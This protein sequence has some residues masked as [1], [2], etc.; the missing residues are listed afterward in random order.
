MNP[1]Q[2]AA[3]KISSASLD[4][5]LSLTFIPAAQ[6]AAQTALHAVY[7][8]LHEVPGEARD[9]GVADVKLRWWEEEIA[10]LYAGK[11]R[12]PLTQALLPHMA[13]LKARQAL[14]LDLI[15]GTR[16]DIAGAGFPSFEDVKRYCFRHSGALSQLSAMLAGGHAEET[17][18]AARLLGNATCLADIAATG[19]AAAL[20]G[21]LYFA[22][23]DL[24]LRGVDKHING[25]T[26]A[27]APVRALVQDYEDR[28][29]A[30]RAAALR[31]VPVAERRAL[32]V[33]QVRSALTLKRARKQERAGSAAAAEPVG[34]HPLSALF[35]AWRAAR[36]SN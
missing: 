28:A 18:L 12:H 32:T 17:L 16:A 21:R 3:D 30:M 2:Q 22:A 14:F 8:E 6:R 9:P 24:K 13:A 25:E 20:G 29:R 23:E 10:F 7:L 27:D 33:W 1:A 15:A 11:P 35:T 36:N 26:H 34:L 19:I 31:S 4:L 5:R